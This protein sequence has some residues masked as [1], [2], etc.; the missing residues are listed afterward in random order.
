MTLYNQSDPVN[1]IEGV[2]DEAIWNKHREE[3]IRYGS[4]LVGPADAED[5]L[6][7][8]VVRILN[9]RSLADLDDPRSYLYRSVTNEAR[10]LVR[11]RSKRLSRTVTT[12]L[13]A[14]VEPE[15]LEAVLELPNRQR[16]AVY[17]A[18]W[19]DLPMV[20][21]A[22]LMGCS[23]G[24]VKRYLHVAKKKLREVLEDE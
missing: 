13:P 8:V 1:V 21:I 15:V 4:V 6:S 14:D 11:W 22:Q 9:R 5:L 16:A 20:E 23:P 10:S 18:Y 7:V 17:L 19:R 3:L 24:S 12:S 2:N